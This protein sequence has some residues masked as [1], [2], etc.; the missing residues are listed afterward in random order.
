MQGITLFFGRICG[1]K[2]LFT[3][4]V[5]GIMLWWVVMWPI[6]SKADLVF[7]DNKAMVWIKVF[8]F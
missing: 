6:E 5:A 1:M 3:I 7:Q 4:S 8:S 2:D